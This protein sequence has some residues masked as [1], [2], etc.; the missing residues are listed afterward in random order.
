VKIALEVDAYGPSLASPRV[1]RGPAVET[2]FHAVE[3]ELRSANIRPPHWN[4]RDLA[5]FIACRVAGELARE[6]SR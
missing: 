3:E 1:V 5:K 6:G 2:I 4:R